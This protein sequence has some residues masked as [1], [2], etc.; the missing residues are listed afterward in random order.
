M[1]F[2]LTGL[3]CVRLEVRSGWARGWDKGRVG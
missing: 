1:I 2:R 3:C